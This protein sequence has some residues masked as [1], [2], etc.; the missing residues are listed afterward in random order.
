[1]MQAV[2]GGEGG[3]CHG[4]TEEEAF[5]GSQLLKQIQKL[6]LKVNEASGFQSRVSPQ[7]GQVRFSLGWEQKRKQRG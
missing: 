7:W 3:P 4:V 2:G 1:M 5:F 6:L